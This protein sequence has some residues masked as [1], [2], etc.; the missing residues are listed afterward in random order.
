[1]YA[2][3]QVIRINLMTS[4][5]LNSRLHLHITILQDEGSN[6]MGSMVTIYD[7]LP[8][9]DQMSDELLGQ[10]QIDANEPSIRAFLAAYMHA[11]SAT[12]RSVPTVAQKKIIILV[13]TE[14]KQS[15]FLPKLFHRMAPPR[16][17]NARCRAKMTGSQQSPVFPDLNQS[18]SATT[19]VSC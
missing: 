5:V 11:C 12:C 8:P 7:V 13:S 14:H 15:N 16:P 1:M 10:S 3:W 4:L 9:V 17:S 2:L 6:R 18:I 19:N